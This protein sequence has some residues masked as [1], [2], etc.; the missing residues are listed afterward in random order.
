[1][2]VCVFVGLWVCV[3]VCVGR[4]G[5]GA[6]VR[7]KTPQNSVPYSKS[8]SQIIKVFYYYAQINIKIIATCFGVNTPSS[9]SL[10]L[11]QLKL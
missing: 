7:S 9:G 5:G 4:G 10:E 11:C 1:M 6:L 2:C 8:I 3:C